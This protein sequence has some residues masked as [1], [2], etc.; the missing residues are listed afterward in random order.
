MAA[1][2]GVSVNIAQRC[3]NTLSLSVVSALNDV[4]TEYFTPIES[5]CLAGLVFIMVHSVLDKKS[6]HLRL[7][8]RVCLLYCNQRARMLF[9]TNQNSL[10]GMFSNLILAVGL[11]ILL[12]MMG[13]NNPGGDL[14]GILEG[15]VYLY[16]DIM[17]FAFRF[18]VL[19]ITLCAFMV[20]F[21]LDNAAEPADPVYR[22]CVRMFKVVSANLLSEGVDLLVQSTPQLELVECLAC[23][24][25]FRLLL[26]SMGSY[27][28]FM[29][30]RRVHVLFPGLA[31]LMFMSV[32]WLDFVP[33]NS[34]GWI[35][36]ICFIYV[37]T[38]ITTYLLTISI[39]GVVIM[40]VL[41]HYID[42]VLA[43][44]VEVQ[45]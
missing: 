14:R 5:L 11:A 10:M 38:S 42:F 32:F 28:V 16:G 19:K 33:V 34:R 40:M 22:F 41:A 9:N 31:P 45:Q 27:L 15:M 4:T 43:S 1:V 39:G 6:I 23:V 18:G 13:E 17:D 7:L 3:V 35:G 37:V 26:P 44:L 2:L 12:M 21:T 29:A 8:Y 24:A 30:A 36:E 25:L 20:G